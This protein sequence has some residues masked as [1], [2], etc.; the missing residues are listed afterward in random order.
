MHQIH[1][2][3]ECCSISSSCYLFTCIPR[4]VPAET[5]FIDIKQ[6]MSYESSFESSF[7]II[8]VW[9][10]LIQLSQKHRACVQ[11]E[12]T[13]SCCLCPLQK[14][15]LA[16]QK[17][18]I[19]STLACIVLEPGSDPAHRSSPSWRQCWPHHPKCHSTVWLCLSHLLSHHQSWGQPWK[20]LC[21][22]KH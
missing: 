19:R 2:N 17:C 16:I 21:Y 6:C 7:F 9:A 8:M 22:W 15:S 4:N 14:W 13:W 5:L 12:E 11:P 3:T 20:I 10:N 1:L 18:T